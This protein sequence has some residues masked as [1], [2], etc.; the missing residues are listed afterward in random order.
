MGIIF[1]KNGRPTKKEK[2]LLKNINNHISNMK[3][4]DTFDFDNE[5]VTEGKRLEDIW[6]SITNVEKIDEPK[7]IETSI[8]NE[9]MSNT[10]YQILEEANEGLEST[11]DLGVPS[12]FN[13]LS[14]PIMQRSYTAQ[15]QT[16]VGEIEEQS[17]EDDHP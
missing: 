3:D 16:N 13:P 12:S 8:N 10:E 6:N 4:S 15:A 9:D 17:D 7:E 2:L 11:N 14:E 5:N 1:K